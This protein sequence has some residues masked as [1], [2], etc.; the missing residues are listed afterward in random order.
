MLPQYSRLRYLAPIQWDRVLKLVQTRGFDISRWEA[1]FKL[2]N[3]SRDKKKFSE[4]LTAIEGKI[5]ASGYF[6][7]SIDNVPSRGILSAT[8][9]ETK[10]GYNHVR[11]TMGQFGRVE[12]II[13]CH[14]KAYVRFKTRAVATTTHGLINGMQMGN[15]IISTRVF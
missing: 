7:F 15:K 1:N 10:S 11:E 6:N 9:Q 13:L 12:D 14:G 8:D 4:V 5:L 2:V 3:I